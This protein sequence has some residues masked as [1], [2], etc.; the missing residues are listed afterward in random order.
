MISDRTQAVIT[1]VRY[2]DESVGLEDCLVLFIDSSGF[3]TALV[4]L[5]ISRKC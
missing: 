5:L 3:E 1:N 2:L 4:I